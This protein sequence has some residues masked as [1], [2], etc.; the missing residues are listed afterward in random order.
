LVASTLTPVVVFIPLAFLDGITGIFFRALAIT[1]VVSLL[2]SLLLAVT[3]TPALAAWFLHE[4]SGADNKPARSYLILPLQNAYAWIVQIAIRHYWVTTSICV[5]LLALGYRGYQHLESDFLPTMDEGGFVIDYQSPWGTS[6]AETD[7]QL[8]VAEQIIRQTSEVQSYSRRTGARLALA[9]AEPNTGDF[10]V[11]L[12]SSRARSTQEIIS[13]FRAQ[14]QAAVPGIEWDFPGILSDLVGDLTWSPK[15]IEIKLFSTDQALLEHLAP[16]IEESISKIH[17]VVDT[18]SGLIYAGPTLSIHVRQ[19]DARRLGLNSDDIAS[20]VNT[21]MLGQVTTTVLRGDRLINIRVVLDPA[22]STTI[23]SLKEFVL[24]SAGGT[25]IK[26]SQVADVLE[27]PGQLELRRE[28]LRQCV[29]V[30]ARLENRDLGSAMAEIRAK[31]ASDPQIPSEMVEY[32][33]LFLQQQQAF[34]NLIMV[35]LLAIGLVFTVL[36]IEFHSFREPLAIIIGSVLSL[37]GSIFAL[38][39]TDTTLNVVSFLGAI[40]GL[41]VVAKNGILMMDGVEQQR[42][43]GISLEDAVIAAGRRR[44]R[45]VLMTSLAAALGMLPLAYGLGTGADMLR[46]LAIAVIGALCVSVLLAL[47]ATPAIYA[48][49]SAGSSRKLPEKSGL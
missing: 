9:L 36:L 6:L 5:V 46:P 1:M 32:G 47:I 7:R 31:L 39:M 42:L 25:L 21:A 24:R 41:G 17:G 12:K 23:A 34:H 30:T 10:L 27:K 38:W 28:N 44:L 40:I 48:L 11:K 35:L 19:Q 2:T 20:A 49:L 13:D 33:G 14:F 15:P 37:T 26:L 4:N 22:R 45:P 18:N 43:Q 8:R 16:Y 3:L 29:A